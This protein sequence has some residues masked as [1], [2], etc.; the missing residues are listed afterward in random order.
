MNSAGPIKPEAVEALLDREAVVDGEE[1]RTAEHEADAAELL[2]EADEVDLPNAAHAVDILSAVVAVVEAAFSL[3]ETT[4]LLAATEP[5]LPPASTQT[6]PSILILLPDP[7]SE[8]PS[9][10]A[11]GNS[12]NQIR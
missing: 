5:Q 10:E 4:L 2:S 11:A 9:S 7:Q 8:A 6:S 3:E 1:S 12:G